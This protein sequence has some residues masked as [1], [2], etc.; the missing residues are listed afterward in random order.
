MATEEINSLPES[1]PML[2]GDGPYSYAKNSTFQRGFVDAT[3]GMVFAGIA[4][5][6]DLKS[7][8][9][10]SSSTFQ[11]A[12]LGCSVGPNTF[13]A[14]QNI[15]EAVEQKY[16]E[17]AN[18][19]HSTLEFRVFFNDH[20]DNDFNTLF[21]TLPPNRKYFAAGVPGSF[22]NRLFP[23]SSLHIVH[24]SSALH[25]LSRV[26]KEITDSTTLA[27]NKGSIH[28]TGFVKEVATAYS[29][30][31]SNDFESFFN[32]RAEEIVPGGLMLILIA[33]RP[34][35]IPMSKNPEGI[36][37]DF[38]GCCLYD[39]AKMGLISEEKVDSFNLPIYYPSLGE[40]ETLIKRNANFS[41][42]K[43]HM[44]TNPLMQKAYCAEFWAGLLRAGLENLFQQHFGSL[45]VVDQIFKYYSR[46]LE[47]NISFIMEGKSHDRIELCIILKRN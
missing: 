45:Q 22:H 17:A 36:H 14:V 44:F 3:K 30:Q 1:Y 43:K 15:I 13:I 47:Q 29:A 33:V 23:K 41:I 6:L 32:A 24:S 40:F 38:L 9:I 34:D 5:K 39:L 8:G 2:G 28:C 18:Q 37:Y 11:I 27:W 42:E 26:P 20:S 21:Q 25:W 19:H 46:K 7:L 12:D 35:G 31:F 4:E 10:Y 16:L